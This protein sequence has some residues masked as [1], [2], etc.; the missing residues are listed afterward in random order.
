MGGIWKRL[1]RSVKTTLKMILKEQVPRY[2]VFHSGVFHGVEN[3][4]NHRPLT[5]VP[6]EHENEEA[7]APLLFLLEPQI[8]P[9]TN[10]LE[11]LVFD[12][13]FLKKQ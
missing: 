11:Y 13:T 9:D 5:A 12:G 3:R 4:L 2:G 10:F 1:I 7:L 8:D 6:L